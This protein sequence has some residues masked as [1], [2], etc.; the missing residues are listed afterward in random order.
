MP[1][2]K[3]KLV[4]PVGFPTGS[5]EP[6]ALLT[7]SEGRLEV[8]QSV[9]TT[10]KARAYLNTAQAIPNDTTTKVSLDTKNYDPSNSFDLANNRF[11]APVAGYYMITGTVIYDNAQLTDQ[12]KVI[13]ELWVNGSAVAY[14]RLAASGTTLQGAS[15]NDI[16]HLNIGDYVELWTYH[17]AGANAN[18]KAGIFYTFLAVHLLSAD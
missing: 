15:A 1:E 12:C 9:H 14:S 10:A 11:V 6:V 5:A 7:D 16:R 8:I 2:P 18:L 17:T 3:G 4:T 13:T